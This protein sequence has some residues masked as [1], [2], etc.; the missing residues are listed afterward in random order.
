MGRRRAHET[1]RVFL[2]GRL[3]GTLSRSPTGALDFR[4][5]PVWLGAADA[6]PVSNSLPLRED[7]YRDD[8]VHA[9]FDNLLPD[10][11]R[12][13]KI[14]AAK[15]GARSA[16]V[17]DLLSLIGRDCVGALQLLPEDV[18]PVPPAK[19]SGVALTERDIGAILRNLTTAPLG[20]EAEADFRI[21]IAGAQEKTALLWLDGRWYR[22][23][24]TTPT[25]HILKPSLGV[26]P[27]RIDMTHSVENEFLCLLL[28]QH[29]GLQV[30]KLDILDFD[31]VRCL[32]VERF[33]RHWTPNAKVVR[34]L[35]QEDLCQA[36]GVPSTRKYESDGG[37]GIKQI[38]QFLDASDDRNGDREAFLRA[39]LTFLLLGAVDGH[40]K[41]FSVFL[42]PT[43]FRLTPVYDVLS[44]EPALQAR[45]L[46]PRQAKLAMCVGRNRHY[47]LA[48][49]YRRHWEQT[50]RAS[51][52][53]V[54]DLA[55]LIED[56][57]ER[58]R[59]LDRVRERLPAV[60]PGPLAEIV[61]RGVIRRAGSLI[62]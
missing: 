50:A 29:F 39:Q 43:G 30:P 38:L 7:A 34:R 11:A 60:I 18:E 32:S 17:F 20:I 16:G 51:G 27:S 24:G 48:E 14:V 2:E 46:G 57:L 35:P 4:Y 1:L 33:D 31:G 61:I 58:T 44:V 23:E 45:Q 6:T 56:M 21:S 5:A 3:V 26:L 28:A 25:T 36:L 59:Q 9:Y 22:P 55:A 54:G 53:P 62:R 52:F 10:S 41:N 49:I 13:R 12:I 47:R 8:R 42:T 15:L 40:A 19:A 37:P